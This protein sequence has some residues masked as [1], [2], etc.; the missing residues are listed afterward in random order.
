MLTSI[1]PSPAPKHTIRHQG[2]PNRPRLYSNLTKF[3]HCQIPNISLHSLT[4]CGALP[5]FSEKTETYDF[6]LH[7]NVLVHPAPLRSPRT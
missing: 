4:Q 2:T 6:L 7:F 3:L 1:V 5:C